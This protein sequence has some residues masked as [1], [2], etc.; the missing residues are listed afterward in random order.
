MNHLDIAKT[1]CKKFGLVFP[2]KFWERMEVLAELIVENNAKLGLVSPADEKDLWERH[3]IDSLTPLLN[4]TPEKGMDCLDIGTGGGFPGIVLASA[5]PGNSF[6]LAECNPLKAS[7][8]STLVST[9]SLQNTIVYA[10]RAE[11][12]EGKFHWAT[13][14]A[15]GPLTR[16]FDVGC[17]KL[18]SNGMLIVWAG[19]KFERQI[20]YWRQFARKRNTQISLWEYPEGWMPEMNLSLAICRKPEFLPV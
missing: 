17:K 8:L 20:E 16:T 11:E 7:F 5:L 10:K 19:P 12:I 14:R 1:R 4:Y 6:S 2:D 15:T 9:L 3:I 13:L 18:L